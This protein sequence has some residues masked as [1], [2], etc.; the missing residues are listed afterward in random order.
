MAFYNAKEQLHL[1]TD[2]FGVR[3]GA[4]LLQARDRMHLPRKEAP[5]SAEL[6]PIAFAKKSL[7][8]I[9]TAIVIIERE[10]LCMFHD[11]EKKFITTASPT[12]SA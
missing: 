3:L 2:V 6:W 1:E 9:K 10:A 7:T 5:N 11:L 4:I 12:K 8:S